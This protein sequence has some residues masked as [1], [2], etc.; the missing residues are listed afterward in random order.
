MESYIGFRGRRDEVSAVCLFAKQC[1]IIIWHRYRVFVFVSSL[2]LSSVIKFDKKCANSTQRSQSPNSSGWQ[3]KLYSP[4][5]GYLSPG[6]SI[7]LGI[8]ATLLFISVRFLLPILGV[9][10][11][12]LKQAS[13]RHVYFRYTIPQKCSRITFQHTYTNLLSSEITQHDIKVHKGW[14]YLGK[15]LFPAKN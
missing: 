2:F 14:K 15:I 9:I 6:N 13:N 12:K 5:R 3:S 11:L 4:R 10:L 1:Q 7:V 8:A